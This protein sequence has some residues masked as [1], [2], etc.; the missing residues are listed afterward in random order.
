M[1]TWIF[2]M[3]IDKKII[4]ATF[5]LTLC[6]CTY[7]SKGSGQVVYHWEKPYTGVQKFSVDHADC[8]VKAKEFTFIPDF[9]SWFYTEE[10]KLDTRAD[11][12]SSKGIWASYIPYAGAQPLI[13]NSRYNDEDIN[14]KDYRVCMESKGYWRR[15]HEI[16]EITNINLYKARNP[17]LRQ[18]FS[19]PDFYE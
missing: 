15:E 13:V 12:K 9:R 2:E 4:S 3:M 19:P 17:M 6:S 7:L 10:T 8:L 11:W 18:P 1:L 5:L 16:P 14:P